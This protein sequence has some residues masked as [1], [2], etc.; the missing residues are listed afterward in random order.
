MRIALTLLLA[1]S[2]V[3]C[4]APQPT[5]D[6]DRAFAD[7]ARQVQ[8]GPRI[9]GSGGH[10]QCVEWIIAQLR[11]LADSVWTQ[12]F[13]GVIL[14]RSDTVAMMNI[15]ARFN[16][17]AGERILLSAHWDTRPHADFDPDSTLRAQPIAGANDGAS[18]VAVLLELAR[19]FDSM[20]PPI[21]VDLAFY[22]GED[23]G[24]YG[25]SPGR[26]CQGSFHF[27]AR[28]PAR[29]RWAINVDMIGDKDLTIPIEANSYRLAPELVDRVWSQAEK[30]GETAFQRARGSD[31]FDDHMPLLAKG[32][33]AI[34]IID[35][36]YPHW[37]TTHDTI[38]KCAPASLTAVGRVLVG[39]VYDL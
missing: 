29:Y 9:P 2:A 15:I 21:G 7:L 34:N 3:A 10:L 22:D 38:D 1:L 17:D 5:F 37:H 14:G 39:V 23:S 36:D 32:I 24:D 31:V 25:D 16:P 26:W 27:A 19:L 35:F 4:A 8:F 28:L 20:P 33:T 13:R 6:G 11:P 30:L 18:G 12:P